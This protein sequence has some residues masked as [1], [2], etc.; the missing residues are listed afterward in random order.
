MKLGKRSGEEVRE[1][2]AEEIRSLPD[3]IDKFADGKEQLLD[4][5]QRLKNKYGNDLQIEII[6]V[7][8]L[9]FEKVMWERV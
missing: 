3:V 4:Y 2:S 1:M 7:V 6:T 8:A 5:K 9:G